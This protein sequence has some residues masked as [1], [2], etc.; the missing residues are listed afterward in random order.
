M[1]K[2]SNGSNARKFAKLQSMLG[3][4]ERET[5]KRDPERQPLLLS[6]GNLDALLHIMLVFRVTP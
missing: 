6:G 1:L 3:S 5:T 4:K 2:F